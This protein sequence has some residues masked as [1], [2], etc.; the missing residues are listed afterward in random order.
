M[1][2]RLW[3]KIQSNPEQSIVDDDTVTVRSILEQQI[4]RGGYVFAGDKSDLSRTIR[5]GELCDLALIKE[6]FYT[7]GFG[8]VLRKGAP[9]KRRF[10][11]V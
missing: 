8:L 11:T 1:Y 3:Q 7:A 5:A 10:D 6:E 2:K 9:Y 4:V